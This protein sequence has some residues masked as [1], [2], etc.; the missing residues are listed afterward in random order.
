MNFTIN[1]P[2]F[3]VA[4]N[5]VRAVVEKSQIMN[6]LGF[7]QVQA[8]ADSVIVTATD[9]TMSAVAAAPADIEE[10]G[11]ALV[12]AE[13]LFQFVK[14]IPESKEIKARLSDHYLVLSAG[15]ARAN[16]PI[17]PIDQFPPTDGAPG[18]EMVSLSIDQITDLLITPRRAAVDNKDYR[19]YFKGVHM[20]ARDGNLI[21]AATDG[22]IL[23][24]AVEPL[25]SGGSAPDEGVIIPSKAIDVLEKAMGGEE[26]IVV[27]AN[28]RTISF[29]GRSFT[30]ISRLINNRYPDYQRIM[31]AVT[32]KTFLADREEALATIDRV[33]CMAD[34]KDKI[35][36]MESDDEGIAVSTVATAAEDVITSDLTAHDLPRL[37]LSYK[38]LLLS[39]S[40]LK[41]DR[42]GIEAEHE[43]KP[44]V[45]LSAARPQD[46]IVLMTA[47]A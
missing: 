22:I 10:Q 28:E 34:D 14:R 47:R 33:G 11:V 27:I 1:Q 45:L 26:R 7:V 16:L 46:R 32:G 41:G 38:R 8:L 4:I 40:I 19:D 17:L 36:V 30:I 15:R 12:E 23:V 31:P 44:C 21:T 39:L 6:V 5:R 2:D 3:L 20:M 24:E 29:Q 42:I 9:M 13:K 18:G 37:A 43:A 25:E 35:I